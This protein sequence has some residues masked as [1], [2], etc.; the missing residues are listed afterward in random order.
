MADEQRRGRRGRDRRGEV[1]FA[2]ATGRRPGSGSG[3]PG[4]RSVSPRCSSTL[5]GERDHR[6]LASALVANEVKA[7]GMY[8]AV[9]AIDGPN[10]AV[11]A[12]IPATGGSGAVGLRH[13][14]VRRRLFLQVE[15][16]R[17]LV[18]DVD[19]GRLLRRQERLPPSSARTTARHRHRRGEHRRQDDHGGRA[20]GRDPSLQQLNLLIWACRR[21]FRLRRAAFLY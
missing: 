20:R 17:L 16:R 6:E 12:A 5:P 13:E 11:P 9:V 10:G 7:V 8:P 18:G 2:G 21:S 3:R 19:R 4:P 14:Q 1:D 15:R